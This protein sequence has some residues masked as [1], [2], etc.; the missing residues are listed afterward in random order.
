MDGPEITS[1]IDLNLGTSTLLDSTEEAS[2][3]NHSNRFNP[4]DQLLGS[5]DD[6]DSNNEEKG[7]MVSK[8]AAPIIPDTSASVKTTADHSLSIPQSPSTY[9]KRPAKTSAVARLAMARRKAKD[10]FENDLSSS[11]SDDNAGIMR[12]PATKRQISSFASLRIDSESESE[13]DSASSPLPSLPTEPKATL[14]VFD[15]K[16]TEETLQSADKKKQRRRQQQQQQPKSRDPNT[17]DIKARAASKAAM[18]KI[19]EESARLIRET[20]VTVDPME[21]TRPLELGE[22]LTKFDEMVGQKTYFQWRRKKIKAA[23]ARASNTVKVTG[24]LQHDSDGEDYELSIVDNDG[25]GPSGAP[26]PNK[27]VVGWKPQDS[28]VVSKTLQQSK[29]EAGGSQL[30]SILKYGSQPIHLTMGSTAELHGM[31]RTGGP[32]ALRDLNKA[33]LDAVYAK[34]TAKPQKSQKRAVRISNTATLDVEAENDGD[35]GDAESGS[36]ADV[37]M[38]SDSE[39]EDEDDLSSD[40][41]STDDGDETMEAKGPVAAISR[42]IRAAV[43][44]DD[45]DDGPQPREAA[46]IEKPAAASKAK[47]LSM[48]KMPVAKPTTTSNSSKRE[49]N[50]SLPRPEPQQPDFSMTSEQ[51]EAD[52]LTASQDPLH[53]LSS[54]VDQLNTQDSLLMTPD[55]LPR[56]NSQE[57]VM[58]FVVGPTQLLSSMDDASDARLFGSQQYPSELSTDRAPGEDVALTPRQDQNQQQPPTQSTEQETQLTAQLTVATADATE[59]GSGD[60]DPL[61]PTMVRKALGVPDQRGFA[62]SIDDSIA[63]NND[64]DDANGNI[65]ASLHSPVPLGDSESQPSGDDNE[66]ESANGLQQ[67]IGNAVPGGRRYIRRGGGNRLAAG[68]SASKLDSRLSRTK[69]RAIRTEFVVAEAEESES[70]DSDTEAAGRG[71]GGKFNWGEGPNG[72]IKA[73]KQNNIDGDAD[74]EEEELDTDEEEAAL[75]ADPMIN[76]DVAENKEADRAIRDLHRQQ[77]LDQDEQ[78]IRDLAKDIATGRLRNRSAA[79]GRGRTG[80]ALAD[81]EDYN[82][83]QTRAERMEERLRQ[84]R[85]LLAREIH[86]TNLAEI[87]KN[88]ETA[89]FAQAALMRGTSFGSG[90][91]AGDSADESRGGYQSADTDG[92]GFLSETDGFELEEQVDDHAVAGA[93]QRQLARMRRRADSEPESDD[94]EGGASR[95]IVG[96]ARAISDA[97]AG[98]LPLYDA[99]GGDLDGDMFA[100]VSVE[101]LIVRRQTLMASS[102][103]GADSGGGA[104]GVR[105]SGAWPAPRTVLKR[106]GPVLV[107]ASTKRANAGAADASHTQ[108]Q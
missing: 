90:G 16:P 11:D 9:L 52:M 38:G 71:G 96:P 8:P 65:M 29:G 103:S 21:Y 55:P 35:D 63:S 86:D 18:T 108:Q 56:Q 77:E 43:V 26:K 105:Q 6:D 45:E 68:D 39:N 10:V 79:N 85:R 101:R 50:G 7:I 30:E 82:D 80:F 1:T 44:S 31:Q 66:E 78:D 47:F 72:G 33:L 84:R 73:N 75:L 93:V 98:S 107:G 19:H 42:K 74:E 4:L 5:D 17:E 22:F 54:Q 58:D 57:S 51:H 46:A 62:G 13:A 25:G 70:T 76:N 48:F 64:D 89:A 49:P 3:P 24:L 87:A 27:A 23:L 41:G 53:L 20:A 88:P 37:A 61:L 97:A 60:G 15:N 32:H 91:G 100:S 12:T 69:K 102:S 67:R 99:D 94:N 83:R 81:E 59:D 2:R 106:A 95:R 14:N 104:A 40:G 36:D 28:S 92:D 34:E